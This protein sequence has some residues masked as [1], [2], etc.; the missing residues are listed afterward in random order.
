MIQHS[1]WDSQQLSCTG[2]LS[3]LLLDDGHGLEHWTFA[4]QEEREGTT[5]CLLNVF[6]LL[7]KRP[8]RPQPVFSQVPLTR[9]GSRPSLRS[10]G[11]IDSVDK[12]T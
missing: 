2:S 11:I 3:L 9:S 1:D 7:D 8:P 4:R 10:D 6:Y 12:V 5:S